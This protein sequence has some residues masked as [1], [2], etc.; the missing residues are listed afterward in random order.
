MRSLSQSMKVVAVAAVVGTAIPVVADSTPGIGATPAHA[1]VVSR[2]S[3]TGNTRVDAETVISYLTIRPNQNFGAAD[4]DAS[5]KALFDTGLFADVRI[6]R[7]AGGLVVAVTENP[8]IARV[9][10]EGNSRHDDRVLGA[11]VEL[12]PRS[13]LTQA[14]VQSDTQ[15][16]QELYRRTGRYN[17]TVE[18]QTI[19]LGQN[20]VA[21]VFNIDEGPRTEIS[22]ISFIGN[23]AFSDGR[24][25]DV[26]QSRESG[27]FGWFRTSDNYDPDRLN[28]DQEALRVFYYKRGYAD[29]RVISAVA[30]FDRDQNAFFIT[31]TVEEGA[32]YTFG[33]ISVETT[34]PELNVDE[35]SGTARTRAGNVYNSEEVEKTLEDLTLA[36]SSKGYAFAQ[37]RPRGERDYENRTISIT[38]FIDE[39]ARTYI[40]R[41]NI[42][43]NSRTRDYVIRREFDIAEGDAY[44]QVLIDKAERRLKNLNFFANVRITAEQGSQPDRVVVNVQVEDQPTGEISVGGGYSSEAGFIVQV[45][46][47]ERNFLGRGQQVRV[48]AGRGEDTQTYDLSF[49]EPFFLDRRLSAGFDV[50]RNAIGDSELLH[51][52]DEVITGGGLR[53]GVPLTDELTLGLNYKIFESEIT[54]I[55]GAG[56]AN[57]GRFTSGT[58]PISLTN[59]NLIE[60]GSRIVSSLGYSLTYSTI[61]NFQ[62]PREGIY[63]QFAQEGAGV[64]GDAQ[65][66]RTTA[67][68]DY[69]Q[70]LLPEWGVIGHV[71]AQAGHVMG[72]GQDLSYR[73]TFR[74]GGDLVR[75]FE[76][77]GIGPRDRSSGYALGGEMYVG[78]TVETIFPMPILP[79]DY[80]FFGSF[81]ADAGTVWG[82]DSG[83]VASTG[84]DVIGDDASIRASVGFGVLWQSPFGLLRANVAYPVLKDDADETQLFSFSAG[85]RF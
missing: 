39:G 48:A 7:S 62:M 5:V 38:Y 26:I 42:V 4:I 17:A 16:I 79:S 80:G 31:F 76:N 1:D 46:L 23:T 67:K 6:S 52:F 78:G 14:K 37:V 68:V 81:F 43:G 61:D 24:L 18:P 3:V 10:F 28:A 21:L 69:Y 32:Q 60:E 11:T 58:D 47:S 73:D 15:R 35:L 9:A 74:M 49:T 30:D 59:P 25:Q 40:E 33:D 34:L 20:R 54:D 84:A 83:T 56:D 8:I 64:G 27:L 77:A 70:E 13:V 36:V 85:T 71:G 82:V 44:N 19:D 66:L 50:Y 63:A 45:S 72:L 22:K 51:P 12:Q 2:I 29:F 65:F 55:R 75:G 57:G 41:I 53:L